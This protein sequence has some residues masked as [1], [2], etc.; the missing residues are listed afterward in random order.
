MIRPGGVTVEDGSGDRATLRTPG[1][2]PGGLRPGDLLRAERLEDEL[3]VRC[4]YPASASKLQAG[5]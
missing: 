5:S 4:V 3:E 1:L 2:D